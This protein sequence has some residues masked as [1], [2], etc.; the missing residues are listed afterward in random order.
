MGFF[1]GNRVEGVESVEEEVVDYLHANPS[2][3]LP[4]CRLGPQS[5]Y[6]K[7]YP[8]SG[9]RRER[10]WDPLLPLEGEVDGTGLSGEW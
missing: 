2:P 6:R 8:S 10:D 9:S 3:H 1:V 7:K 5:G 4:C